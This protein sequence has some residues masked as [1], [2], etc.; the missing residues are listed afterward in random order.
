M[1]IREIK[2]MEEMHWRVEYQK[3]K[4]DEIRKVLEKPNTFDLLYEAYELYPDIRKRR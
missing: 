1:A 2:G 4:A 3:R